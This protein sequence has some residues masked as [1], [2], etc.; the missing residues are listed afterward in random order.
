MEYH[1]MTRLGKAEVKRVYI[2][3]LEEII[4]LVNIVGEDEL[5][6]SVDEE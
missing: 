4:E 1:V 5:E 3:T 2:G 6:Y